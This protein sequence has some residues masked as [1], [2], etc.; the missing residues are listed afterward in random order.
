MV[1]VTILAG[2]AL[3][4]PPLAVVLAGPTVLFVW[5][6]GGAA[7]T[8]WWLYLGTSVGA[9]DLPEGAACSI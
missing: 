9:H 3:V 1:T 2:P 4:S 8:E 6:D 5:T 7:V